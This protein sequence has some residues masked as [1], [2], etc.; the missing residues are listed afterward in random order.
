MVVIYVSTQGQKR[1]Y[2]FT[3]ELKEKGRF[4]THN[5]LTEYSE[6][7]IDQSFAPHDYL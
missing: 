2:P 7:W 3:G 6:K 4:F 1:V 5:L